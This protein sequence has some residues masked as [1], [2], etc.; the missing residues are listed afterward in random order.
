MRNYLLLVFFICFFTTAFAQSHR[1]WLSLNE[2]WDFYW[3]Y[4]MRPNIPKEKVNL[5]HTWNA[6]E[7]LEEKT[8]YTR[9]AAFYEKKI[10]LPA[11]TQQQ[12]YFLYFE[13]ANSF[14]QVFVN[15]KLAGEHKGDTLLFAWKLRLW[16]RQGKKTS[17]RCGCRM[18]CVRIFCH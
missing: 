18:P 1:Q 9:D 8:R 10:Q 6:Q 4:D 2:G 16:Y 17:Y 3:A 7:A 13:G 12:R 5:P 11:T 15:K 14:A